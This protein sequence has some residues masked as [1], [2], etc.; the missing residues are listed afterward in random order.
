[1]ILLIQTIHD[2]MQSGLWNTWTPDRRRA[3]L[4]RLLDLSHIHANM[5]PLTFEP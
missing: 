1:M 3:M 4:H 2:A 5:P